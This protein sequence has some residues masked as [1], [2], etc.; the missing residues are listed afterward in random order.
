[1]TTTLQTARE[2]PELPAGG[3]VM[4]VTGTATMCV[5]YRR[6]VNKTQRQEGPI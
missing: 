5:G 4:S 3:F 6:I 1:M 2:V